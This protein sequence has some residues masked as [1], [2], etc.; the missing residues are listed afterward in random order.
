MSAVLDV[1]DPI[2][3]EY[4]LRGVF[5][6]IDRLLFKRSSM[7]VC[8]ESRLKYAAFPFEGRRKFR[9]WLIGIE[10]DDVVVR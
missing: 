5:A 7:A 9:G 3:G 2:Q 8:R 4:T 1:E 10:G 6:G